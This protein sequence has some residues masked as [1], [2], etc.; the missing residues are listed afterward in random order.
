VNAVERKEGQTMELSTA[1]WY[2]RTTEIL[3]QLFDEF[4]ILSESGKY[5]FMNLRVL[6][7]SVLLNL[8]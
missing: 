4:G 1:D 6:V 5:A 8:V 2:L 7:H 3:V